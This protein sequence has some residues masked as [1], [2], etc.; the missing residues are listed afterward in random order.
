MNTCY[1]WC[2]AAILLVRRCQVI[3]I[4]QFRTS[5]RYISQLRNRDSKGQPGLVAKTEL[6]SH[7][8]T[9]VVGSNFL[10]MNYTERSCDVSP[11]SDD[12]TPVKDVPIVQAA[13]GYTSANGR[14]YLLIVNEALY[15]PNLD[16]SLLNPNQL[17]HFNID[18]QDNPYADEPMSITSQDD[19]FTACLL[20]Q[21]T[22]IYLDTWCP[23]QQDLERLPK[24]VL[25]SPAEWNPHQVEFPRSSWSDR[26]DL[27]HRNVMSVNAMAF[28][29]RPD[30]TTNQEKGFNLDRI[31]KRLIETVSTRYDDHISHI[32][33]VQRKEEFNPPLPIALSEEELTGVPTF[34]SHKR[35]SQTTPKD[36]SER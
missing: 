23:S 18:V 20:S 28:S 5:R 3:R 11:Y 12:Y 27:E 32:S 33:A 19:G 15:M 35:H 10:V 16:H 31:N 7:A 17:R 29:P 30:H 36:L 1:T 4:Q 13:T 24:V 34:I 22:T 25:S 9:I 6:D 2:A 26:K 14:D 21:G 8:D